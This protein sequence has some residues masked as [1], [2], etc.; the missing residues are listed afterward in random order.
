[1]ATLPFFR[2]RALARRRTSDLD[3]LAKQY[4]QQVDQ[5]TGQYQEAFGQYQA[6]VA[7]QMKP[8]D[9]QM[10]QYTNVAVPNYEASKAKYQEQLDAYNKQLADLQ[11]NPTTTRVIS[12]EEKKPRFGLFGIAGYT[13]ETKYMTVEDPKPVPTF[14]EKMPEAPTAP[15]APQV[16]QFDTAQF[17]EQRGQLESTF[18]REVGERKAGRLA[19]VS[20]RVARPLLQG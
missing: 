16:D 15:T 17:D 8:F 10:A 3:L 2:Q 9:E 14:T 5:M 11:A 13:T 4:K 20:R 6:K 7:E 12:Y 19:A 18:K 1:M